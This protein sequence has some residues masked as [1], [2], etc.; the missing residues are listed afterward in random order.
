MRTGFVIACL[1]LNSRLLRYFLFS[2][3][4]TAW[5]ADVVVLVRQDSMGHQNTTTVV[6]DHPVIA[7]H[8][9]TDDPA[10]MAEPLSTKFSIIL[11]TLQASNDHAG[12]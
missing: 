12:F 5:F 9:N 6:A 10:V 2:R 11:I 8:R 3:W 7:G 4:L 1:G